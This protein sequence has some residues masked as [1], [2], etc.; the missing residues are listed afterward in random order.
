[1]TETNAKFSFYAGNSRTLRFTVID[2]DADPEAAKDLSGLV[3]KWAL[4]RMA[5]GKY[6][7]TPVLEKSS[8]TAG[9]MDMSSAASGVVDVILSDADTDA[10]LGDFWYELEAF[11]S[12]SNSSEVV[13]VGPVT[14]LLNV[15]NT[16]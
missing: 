15:E 7:K 1:M 5:N 4:V 13:A 9:H 2:K 8:A 3:M 10:L 16:L 12:G 6:L 14:I 11:D